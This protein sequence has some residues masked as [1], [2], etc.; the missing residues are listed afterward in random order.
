MKTVR[1][2]MKFTN[3]IIHYPVLI[4]TV[5]SGG[6]LLL[7]AYSSCF[8]PKDYPYLAISGLLFSVLL[9]IN[10]CFAVIWFCIRRRYVFIVLM[11]FLLCYPQI[12]SHIPFHLHTKKLPEGGI[13]VM[14][15]NVMRFGYLKKNSNKNKNAVLAYVK[16]QN[17]DI[18]CMQ[19]YDASNN[20]NYLTQSDIDEALKS[21]PYHNIQKEFACYSKFPI[22]SAKLIDRKTNLG[23]ACYELKIGKDTVMLIN[24]HLKS[25][26]LTKEDKAIYEDMLK[27]ST[28]GSIKRETHQL[29]AKLIDAS[30]IRAEQARIIAG[31]ISSSPHPYAVV[32]GDFN[33]IS[34]SYTHRVISQGLKDAFIQSGCG[35]GVSYN[36]NRF[37][38][39]IDHILTSK[40]MKVYNC[41]VDRSIKDSDHYPIKCYITK[42]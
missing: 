33:D 30:I 21:Y 26:K 5:F 27:A 18:L 4:L 37:Y 10:V 28:T 22:L 20:K 40:N 41:I 3:K 31:E 11:A 15:Y 24:C 16:K 34:I 38:F 36:E 9:V 42:S 13:N 32:C 19:E 8:Y 6:L 39:R 35:M 12:Q 1:K 14:S 25:N 17:V 29:T 2:R 7:S 23:A